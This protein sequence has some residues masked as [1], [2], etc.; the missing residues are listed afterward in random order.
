MSGPTSGRTPGRLND[1]RT[2]GPAGST[3]DRE[4]PE[5]TD[6]DPLVSVVLPT[7]ERASVL[8][9]AIESVLAQSYERLELIV[10]DGGSTDDTPAVVR[11]FSDPRLRYVRRDRPRGVSAARND[12]IRES[13]GE[14][15]AFVDSDDRWREDKLRRQVTAYR[16]A[17]D[18]CGVVYTGMA[19]EYG[20]PH[21]RDGAS[22]DVYRE[23]LTMS[24]PTYT[25]TLLV[26]RTALADCGGFDERL[27]CFEDWEL[28]LRLARAYAFE[29]VDAPLVIKGTCGDNVSAD[30]DA[31][32]AA[33]DRLERE[34]DLPRGTLARL[35]GDA[36]VTYCEAGRLDESRP[37]LLRSLRL[38]PAQ[39]NTAAALLFS[40]ANSPGLFDALMGRLYAVERRFEGGRFG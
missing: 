37:Y 35:L 1:R 7:Y 10:V 36:G 12:G 28:C 40:L 29:Y 30:P 4:G 3:A 32:V 18:A 24:V 15:V 27:P 26:A 39:P 14:L 9:E 11:S 5:P 8:D 25:S 31:L 2:D 19:K 21:S 17:T 34:Y 13:S 20:E 38:N 33:V 16:R 6:S 22:G 23:V